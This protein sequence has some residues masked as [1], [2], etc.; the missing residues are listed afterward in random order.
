M[1]YN[2]ATLRE[3]IASQNE[4]EASFDIMAKCTASCLLSM[5]ENTLLP[6]EEKC[7]RNCFIKSH[8][9]NDY[10]QMEAAYQIRTFYAQRFNDI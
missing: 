7:F 10:T 5:K 1:S 2:L 4:D 6:T 3:G 8:Q 9:F